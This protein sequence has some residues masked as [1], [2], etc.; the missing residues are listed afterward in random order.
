METFCLYVSVPPF[1]LHLEDTDFNVDHLSPLDGI[2]LESTKRLDCFLVSRKE[3]AGFLG[4]LN[5]V[6]IH[7]LDPRSHSYERNSFFDV[8]TQLS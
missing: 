1:R 4:I 5:Y 7:T 8:C 2:L 6:Q 3:V